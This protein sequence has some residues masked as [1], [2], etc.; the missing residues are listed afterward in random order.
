MPFFPLILGVTTVNGTEFDVSATTVQHL[1]GTV[2][3]QGNEERLQDCYVAKWDL[4]SCPDETEYA[5]VECECKTSITLR[6]HKREI[7][8]L[9][10]LFCDICM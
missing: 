8:S 3:C 6:R 5:G 4:E 9:Q 2:H 7:S 1:L 10:K